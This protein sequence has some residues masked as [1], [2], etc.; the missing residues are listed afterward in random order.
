V[1]LTELAQIGEFIG[2]IAVV[3]TLIY[4]AVQVKQGTAALASARHHEMLDC[5]FRNAWAPIFENR[6]LAEFLCKAEEHPDQLD[7]VDWRRFVIHADM[8]YAMWEDAYVSHKRGLIDDEL[9]QGWDGG[10]RS[11]RTRRG[12]RKFWKQERQGHTPLFQKYIDEE[13]FAD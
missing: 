13:I 8:I 7:E 9:W 6:D 5:A 1:T 2:G 4:L 10:G 3:I 12:F 11:L